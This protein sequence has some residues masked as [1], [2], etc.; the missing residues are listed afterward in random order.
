MPASRG[1]VAQRGFTLVEILI[2]LVVMAIGIFSVARLFP[3]GARG[4]VQNRL[5]MGAS[6]Y[7]QEKIEYLRGLS[8]SDTCLTAG[9][10][11]AAS[12]T[13]SCGAGQWQRY[14]FVTAMSSPMDNI[15]KIDVTVSWSGA[16]LHGRSY[17]TTTYVRQ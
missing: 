3:A 6:D 1:S 12:A 10:H 17:T 14:W 5:T 11:P 7:A 13:E 15:K 4:Q 16:G 2:A 9:R 8:W